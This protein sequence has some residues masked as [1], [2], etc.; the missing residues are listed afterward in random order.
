MTFF[1]YGFDKL[2]S[3]S[4]FQ[5]LTRQQANHIGFGFAGEYL[6]ISRRFFFNSFISSGTSKP[7]INPRPLIFFSSGICVQFI[8]QIF[9]NHSSIA[10][11]FFFFNYFQHGQCSCTGQMIAS[12]GS[13]Q[14]KMFGFDMGAMMMPATGKP[15]P[16]PFAMV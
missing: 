1:F 13:A 6:L 3:I 2:F 7:I 12:K 16:I 11:Q 4:F 14:L 5:S 8:F 15:L 9:S 10:H